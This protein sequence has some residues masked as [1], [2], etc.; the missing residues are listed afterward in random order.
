MSFFVQ[1]FTGFSSPCRDMTGPKALQGATIDSYL[2]PD[3]ISDGLRHLLSQG[4][5]KSDTP[6]WS[7]LQTRGG[8]LDCAQCAAWVICDDLGH[9][10]SIRLLLGK[11]NTL[12]KEQP[13]PALDFDIPHIPYAPSALSQGFANFGVH[14]MFKIP[15]FCNVWSVFYCVWSA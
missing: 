15:L 6:S 4:Q 3:W 14:D 5:Y 11:K 2:H 8:K 12:R 9:M 1:G 10:F 13:F 7:V